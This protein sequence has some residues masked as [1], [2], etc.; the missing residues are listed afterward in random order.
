M[1]FGYFSI[2]KVVFV[3]V[4]FNVI[5]VLLAYVMNQAISNKFLQFVLEVFGYPTI[6]GKGRIERSQTC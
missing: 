1:W 4:F 6:S 2:R 3:F 5:F